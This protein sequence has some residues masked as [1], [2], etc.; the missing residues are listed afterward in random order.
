MTE[1]AN[2]F[3]ELISNVGFPIV[4]SFYLLHHFD[5]KMDRMIENLEELC[6][7]FRSQA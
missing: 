3:I 6:H 1:M 4:I 7:L 5:K 2:H